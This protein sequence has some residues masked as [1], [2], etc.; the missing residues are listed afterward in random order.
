M[1][2]QWKEGK[3]W[4]RVRKGQQRFLLMS[5]S[6]SV[7]MCSFIRKAGVQQVEWVNNSDNT[8]FVA[9]VGLL[10]FSSRLFRLRP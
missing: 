3:G 8:G 4:R 2:K 9:T 1:S 10:V 6:K 7:M 5:C